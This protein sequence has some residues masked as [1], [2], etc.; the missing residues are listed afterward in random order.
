MRLSDA[1]GTEL[2]S[3]VKWLKGQDPTRDISSELGISRRRVDVSGK[4]LG[5]A[6]R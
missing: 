1:R 5:A 3:K 6:H 2:H 4:I